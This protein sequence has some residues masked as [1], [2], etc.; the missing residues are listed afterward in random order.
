M[1]AFALW[2][3]SCRDNRVWTICYLAL[4]R[5]GSL[6][7]G[8]FTKDIY[9]QFLSLTFVFPCCSLLFPSL[10]VLEAWKEGEGDEKEQAEG[11]W[12]WIRNFDLEGGG[13]KLW[14]ASRGLLWVLPPV[15]DPQAGVTCSCCPSSFLGPLL[16]GSLEFPTLRFWQPQ[17][18]PRKEADCSQKRAANNFGDSSLTAWPTHFLHPQFTRR[19]GGRVFLLERTG[20]N[21][22]I[23]DTRL[24]RIAR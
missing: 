16:Q 3:Q 11:F 4:Y 21:Q 9:R 17:Q 20:D 6:T 23:L 12:P 14:D 2:R 13:H 1:A 5:E 15:L 10:P 19:G 22:G 24:T 7:T 18:W 8:H